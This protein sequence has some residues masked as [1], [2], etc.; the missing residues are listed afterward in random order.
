MIKRSG[1]SLI[2]L[3]VVVGIMGI[4]LAAGIATYNQMTVRSQVEAQ[5]N[6]VVTALRNWQKEAMSG[7]GAEKCGGQAFQGIQVAVSSNTLV[8]NVVC[9]SATVALNEEVLI[10]NN[11]TISTS[12]ENPIQFLVVSGKTIGITEMTLTKAGVGFKVTVTAVGGISAT[13][14]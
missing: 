14:I 6:A 9:D 8:A 2:E 3:L 4:L 7:V 5:A 11:V 1:Y 12:G 10:G 13:K